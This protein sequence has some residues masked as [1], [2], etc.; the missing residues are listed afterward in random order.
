MSPVFVDSF[1]WI[2]RIDPRDQWHRKAKEMET[3]LAA[4]QLVTT[5][6]V[7]TEVLAFFAAQD[8]IM[9]NAAARLVDKVLANPTVTVVPQTNELFEA[10]FRLYKKRSD[11][12]WSLTDCLSMVVMDRSGIKEILT[13]D[14]HFSQA[15]FTILL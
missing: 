10:A 6:E 12:N 14:H 15:N 8:T 3:T 4:R 11:K 9:R 2:A 7:L 13:H 5:Y 1:Y